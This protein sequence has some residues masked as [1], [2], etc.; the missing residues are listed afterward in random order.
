MK[1]KN[2]TVV[3]VCVPDVGKLTQEEQKRFYAATVRG[4]AARRQTAREGI[5]RS[6]TRRFTVT[7]VTT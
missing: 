6:R 3:N 7:A 2:I 1:Q 5:C 4:R